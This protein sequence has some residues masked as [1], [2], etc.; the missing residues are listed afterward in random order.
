M[1]QRH[2]PF[3]L[4]NKA[5]L[6]GLLLCGVALCTV[7]VLDRFGATENWPIGSLAF[8]GGI[9]GWLFAVLGA[10]SY[11]LGAGA[12]AMGKNESFW[13]SPS[14]ANGALAVLGATSLWLTTNN[15]SMAIAAITAGAL[16]AM[17]AIRLTTASFRRLV[18]I[19]LLILLLLCDA[20][21]NSPLAR[22]CIASFVLTL[23]AWSTVRT[24]AQRAS[25]PN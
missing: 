2:S 3:W 7:Y 15:A 10:A 11:L 17:V 21:A 16:L 18:P 23:N 8:L 9:G 4:A 25:V 20:F 22:F 14:P 13:T 24:A 5:V 6:F 12:F 19:A 1:A